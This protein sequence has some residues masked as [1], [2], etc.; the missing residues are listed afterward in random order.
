MKVEL[1]PGDVF[2]SQNP[3]GLGKAILMAE[4]SKSADEKAEYGHTGIILDASGRTLEAVWS[5]RMQ[6][7]FVNYAGTKVIIARWKSMDSAAFERG[8]NGVKNQVGRRYPYHRLLFHLLGVARWIRFENTPVCSELTS[9]FL[10]K[11]GA[12]TLE[13]DKPWGCTPDNLVDEWRISKFFD[14]IYEGIL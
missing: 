8:W 14:V 3:Q 1:K 2:A 9:M 11:T 13:G 7:L 12:I 6:N 4:R 5:I 10:I